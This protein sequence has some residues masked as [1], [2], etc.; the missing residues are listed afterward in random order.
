MY[1]T[2]VDFYSVSSYIYYCNKFSKIG[3]TC[4]YI[5]RNNYDFDIRL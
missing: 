3:E 2:Y 1:T 4:F 5:V